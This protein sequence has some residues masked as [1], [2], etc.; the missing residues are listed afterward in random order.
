MLSGRAIGAPH[1]GFYGGVD[2]G[3]G[4][5]G[6]GYFGGRWDNGRFFYNSAANNLGPDRITNV[7]DQ[8]I[9]NNTT[10][11]RASFNG[12][13]GG[14]AAKPTDEEQLAERE[15][16]V[17]ATRLQVDHARAASMR[18]EQFQS[19]NK[20]KPAI[21]ATERP[22]E[23]KGK[24]VVPATA[25]GKA[26]E[27]APAPGGTVE[28]SP[29]ERPP[30]NGK[31]VKPEA[32]PNA[33]RTEERLP[34]RRAA[35]QDRDAAQ[36]AEESRAKRRTSG[37]R[38]SAKRRPTRRGSRKEPRTSVSQSG[39]RRRPT[40][41][42]SEEKRPPVENPARPRPS[43]RH[44]AVRATACGRNPGPKRRPEAKECGRPGLPPCPR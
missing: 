35:R 2:Y 11:N 22:G 17:P 30:A 25:A 15:A 5:N 6:A 41:R 18:G 21:A 36:R 42:E 3:F 29:K 10:V 44:A 26:A 4:Y 19:T 37:S 27:T 14:V 38:S 8:T 39:P 32:A 43:E 40:R 9:V 13:A 31:H 34:C 1:V 7:Y 20:G 28:P 16:H 24:G 12:G 23:F 33:P